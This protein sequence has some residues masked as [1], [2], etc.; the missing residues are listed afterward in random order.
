MAVGV[1]ELFGSVRIFKGDMEQCVAWM[2]VTVQDY[3]WLTFVNFLWI[4]DIFVVLIID[5]GN[6]VHFKVYCPVTD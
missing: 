1:W 2:G 6:I 4:N 5:R 3:F